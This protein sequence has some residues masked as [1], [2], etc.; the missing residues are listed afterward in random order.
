MVEFI[1]NGDFSETVTDGGNGSG[2]DPASWTITETDDEQVQA[3]NDQV[4]FNR[5]E[6]DTGSQ[7][8]QSI[9]GVKIGDTAT[10]S[11]DY[12]EAGAGQDVSVFV[13]ILDG[14]G[15]VVFSQSVTTAG[16][17]VQ[18]TFTAESNDYTIRI[19]D[20]SVNPT[21][22]DAVI[23]NVSFDA[24]L[25]CFASGTLI[26]TKSGSKN[27][28]YLKV[29]DLVETFDNGLQEIRWIG[30]R[31]V[32]S[33]GLLTNPELYPI[34]IRKGALGWGFPEK[35]LMVS[36]QHR[37]LISSKI[38]KRIFDTAEVLVAA[39]KLV[40]IDGIEVITDVNE[41]D[42][43]HILFDQHELVFAN[44]IIAESLLPGKQAL[45]AVSQE[46]REEIITLFPEFK[47]GIVNPKPAR[48]IANHGKLVKRMIARHIQNEKNLL[49]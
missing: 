23:D 29:G 37:I 2:L 24:T 17:T 41:V 10:F 47:D 32:N 34:R 30:S 5:T 15:T 3:V 16:T 35:D 18:T 13:E 36:P 48:F 38:A 33:A 25:V 26:E 11:M 22:H 43:F 7:I 6:S 1:I 39:N 49:S 44:G 19:T 31:H 21:A 28:E 14:D 8:E 9:T 27:V 45:Q 4:R 46:A 20:T 42:Y 12:D 40:G